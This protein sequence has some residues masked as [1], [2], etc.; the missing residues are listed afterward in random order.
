MSEE[1]FD[2][3]FSLEGD[4]HLVAS[5]AAIA[6]A[7]ELNRLLP[8]SD[9]AVQSHDMLRCAIEVLIDY[10]ES[11]ELRNSELCRIIEDADELRSEAKR[12][13]KNAPTKK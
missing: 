4:A 3:D 8:Q 12:L 9:I 1:L 13:M 11:Q 7:I 2:P 10:C 5:I 6:A